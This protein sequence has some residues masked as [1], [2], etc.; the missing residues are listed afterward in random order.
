MLRLRAVLRS[1]PGVLAWLWAVCRRSGLARRRFRPRLL[2]WTL[3]A[4]RRLRT[5]WL[6]TAYVRTPDI[7]LALRGHR[8]VRPRL[9]WIGAIVRLCRRR[10]IFARRRRTR[11]R[12]FGPI[13]RSRRHRLGTIRLRWCWTIIPARRRSWFAP[14]AGSGLI[15][16]RLVRLRT[17]RLRRRRPIVTHGRCTRFGTRIRCRLI[18]LRTPVRRIG[19]PR[20]IIHARL[21]CRRRIS[22]RTAIL[23]LSCT[24]RCRGRLCRSR[25]RSNPY[26]RCRSVRRPQFG[27]FLSRH[28]HSWI[29]RQE[30]LSCRK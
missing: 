20:A 12:R 24:R 4:R 22:T 9:I 1:R 29:L 8:Y 5:I 13:V 26:R 14:I 27:Q 30:F 23:R 28:R 18:R 17:V 7:W 6:R 19:S 3:V 11:P 15:R 10:P 25:W 16:L 21:V 2:R